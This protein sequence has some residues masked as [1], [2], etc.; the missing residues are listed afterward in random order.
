[1]KRLMLFGLA[2]LSASMLCARDMYWIGGTSGTW[3][4]ATWAD[5]NGAMEDP[6]TGNYVC[7]VTNT[8]PVTITVPSAGRT[9]CRLVFTGANHKITGGTSPLKFNNNTDYTEL[10]Y[11][12]VDVAEGLTVTLD[13]MECVP[14]VAIVGL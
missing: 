6:Q 9:V 12:G 8:T 1:M 4:K 5:V 13:N 2:A 14:I 7:Y 3:S 10:T 11:A